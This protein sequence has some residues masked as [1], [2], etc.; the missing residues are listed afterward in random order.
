MAC[1]GAL[2]PPLN[3][4]SRAVSIFHIKTFNTPAR[5]RPSRYG[6]EHTHTVQLRR[7]SR[8]INIRIRRLRRSIRLLSALRI[9]GISILKFASIACL[10]PHKLHQLRH[11]HAPPLPDYGSGSR[12]SVRFGKNHGSRVRCAHLLPAFSRIT[13]RQA[14]IMTTVLRNSINSLTIKLPVYYTPPVFI[15]MEPLHGHLFEWQLLPI[16]FW[17]RLG[18]ITQDVPPAVISPSADDGISMSLT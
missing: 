14:P 10:M 2:W 15:F 1:A 17:L 11:C 7:S 13:S 18:K 6:L 8:P 5:R 16:L 4:S 3:F 9:V 12:R